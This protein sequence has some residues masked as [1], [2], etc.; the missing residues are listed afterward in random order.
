MKKVFVSSA[1]MFGFLLFGSI[2]PAEANFGQFSS[3]SR[4]SPT[5]TYHFNNPRHSSRFNR[6]RR[7]RSSLNSRSVNRFRQNQFNRRHTSRFIPRTSFG[8]PVVYHDQW[9][10]FSPYKTAFTGY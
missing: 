3:F 1:L 2:T 10:S 7:F 9:G 5:Y 4:V 6:T 8:R